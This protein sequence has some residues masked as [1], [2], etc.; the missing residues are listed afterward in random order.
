[1]WLDPPNELGVAAATRAVLVSTERLVIALVDC[2]AYSTGFEFAVAIRSRDLRQ[3]LPYPIRVSD[4]D[5]GEL[6]ITV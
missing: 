6:E 1:M 3:K 4:R 5:E 2:V